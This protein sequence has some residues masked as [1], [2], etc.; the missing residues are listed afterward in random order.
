[1]GASSSSVN[2]LDLN[3]APA[4]QPIVMPDVQPEVPAISP[5][6][7]AIPPV[8]PVAH[9][10][11]PAAYPNVWQPTFVFDNRPITIHDSVMLH[12][13][14]AVAVAKGF[15]IPRDQTFLADRSDTDAINNSLAFSIQGAASV[16]DMAQRLSARNVE[17]KVS[18]NQIGVLQRL[19]KYYKRKHVDLKQENTQLKKMMLSYAEYLGP[20]MLE[21]EKNTE[22]LQRQH[23]K[24]RVDVQGCCK[25]LHTRS[26]QVPH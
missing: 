22:R 24:L 3:V 1:M 2:N 4:A 21:M 12:D 25:S 18:R 14:T 7:P 16:S 5:E 20:K 15:V 6:V 9:P 17:L 26:S 10:N 11:E 23:E 8:V 19:L 13:S